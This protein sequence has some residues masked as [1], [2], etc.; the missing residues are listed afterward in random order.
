MAPVRT[1]AD[2]RRLDRHRADAAACTTAAAPESDPDTDQPR[3]AGSVADQRRVGRDAGADA[4]GALDADSH[5]LDHHRA[6][7]GAEPAAR[8]TAAAPGAGPVADRRRAG[9]DADADA[10][11]ALGRRIAPLGSLSGWP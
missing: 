10:G 1:A 3:G 11:G 2:S 4:G 5:R 6:D 7:G 8:A 9:R